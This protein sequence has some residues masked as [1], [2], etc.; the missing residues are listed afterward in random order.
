M[1]NVNANKENSGSRQS[2]RRYT[3]FEVIGAYIWRCASKAR[4]ELKE[5]QPTVVKFNV[6]IRNRLNPPL[7]QIFW[8]CL[9]SNSYP[10]ELRRRNHI[11]SVELHD[12]EDKGSSNEYIRSQMDFVAKQE[13]WD[14]IRTPYLERGEYK[15]DVP[16]FGNPNIIFV[17]WMSLPAYEADFGWGKPFYFGPGGVCP[18]ERA[19]IF[20]RPQEDNH[21][22][23]EVVVF[24]H[25]QEAYMQD[26][27]KFFW[28]DIRD[29]SC[30][31]Q[32]KL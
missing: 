30:S 13:R 3:R 8:E 18:Y 17:S 19:V 14:L 7:P 15:V 23:E 32:A 4:R 5:N 24:M 25:F 6:N 28:E 1:K 31:T 16:F 21:G 9:G 11:S 29:S 20:K 27:I 10:D 22:D 2:Q 12:A 26:F